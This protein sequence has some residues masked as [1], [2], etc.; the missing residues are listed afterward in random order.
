MRQGML[1]RRNVLLFLFRIGNFL[2]PEG[3]KWFGKHFHFPAKEVARGSSW[4][5]DTISN[6]SLNSSCLNYAKLKLSPFTFGKCAVTIIDL[7]WDWWLR[8]EIGQEDSLGNL[9]WLKEA[10]EVASPLA[11]IY[12]A[13]GVLESQ[14]TANSLSPLLLPPCW[15]GCCI[16]HRGSKPNLH[17][18]WE[19]QSARAAGC[20][21]KTE[22][23]RRFPLCHH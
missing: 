19:Q 9:E 14:D 12:T 21:A 5:G 18:W 13:V 16:C 2:T 17:P 7:Y 6:W 3:G 20:C 11:P 10:K 8:L 22:D 15:A 1:L 23:G 4:P